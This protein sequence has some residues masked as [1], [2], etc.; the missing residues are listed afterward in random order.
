MRRWRKSAPPSKQKDPPAPN[1]E[2]PIQCL[3]PFCMKSFRSSEL[4]FHEIMTVTKIVFDEN[5]TGGSDSAPQSAA[6]VQHEARQHTEPA[7]MFDGDGESADMPGSGVDDEAGSA[8]E[9][10]EQRYGVLVEDR[11]YTET[12][13]KYGSTVGRRHTVYQW[14][15]DAPTKE[16]LQVTEWETAL[17][18]RVPRFAKRYDGD[19]ERILTERICPHCHCE[20]PGE[21]FVASERERVRSIALI[22]GTRS[23]KTQYMLAMLQNLK[24]EF[25]NELFLGHVT[26]CN[27]SKLFIDTLEQQFQDSKRTDTTRVG[28]IFPLL[29]RIDP[30]SGGEPFF[31][32]I[33]DCAG[34]VF[35]NISHIVNQA[36]LKKEVAEAALVLVDPA[37]IWGDAVIAKETDRGEH[38]SDTMGSLLTKIQQG[39]A[40]TGLKQ[41]AVVMTKF[42]LVLMRPALTRRGGTPD[43]NPQHRDSALSF[44]NG[45]L[46]AHQTGVSIHEINTVHLNMKQFV[47]SNG[48]GRN[49]LQSIT[50]MLG[51]KDDNIKCFC[52]STYKWSSDEERRSLAAKRQ[53]ERATEQ[54]GVEQDLLIPC[55]NANPERHRLIEPI[56]YLMAEWKLIPTKKPP[57]S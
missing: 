41:V 37:Q 45:S 42:D 27:D 23:G 33:F 12:M 32:R 36:G 49:L 4:L 50:D 40:L 16:R 43:G 53:D 6:T 2:T 25:S 8:Q 48:A 29:I 3:C 10:E 1:D 9:D 17:E 18:Q 31:L 21:Y 14:G 28:A 39:R 13:K 52:V 47:Y 15:K 34:E 56:L 46:S 51:T 22:G 19:D 57:T 35:N 55:V 11:I 44:Y 26:V 20:I 5:I 54:S 7:S 30:F 38:Y 24:L